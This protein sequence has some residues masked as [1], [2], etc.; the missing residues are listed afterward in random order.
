MDEDEHR[1]LDLEVV[2]DEDGRAVEVAGERIGHVGDAHRN[3][4]AILDQRLDAIEHLAQPHPV[5]SHCYFFGATA[6]CTRTCAISCSVRITL[7]AVSSASRRVTFA[8][9]SSFNE[10][11]TAF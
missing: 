10:P 6:F 11:S 4:P 3:A 1:I 5:D 8:C 7:Y 2:V 9:W